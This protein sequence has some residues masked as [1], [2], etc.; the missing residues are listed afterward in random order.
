MSLWHKRGDAGNK[1]ISD[2]STVLYW[3]TLEFNVQCESVLQS[4]Q[5]PPAAKNTSSNSLLNKGFFFI[6]CGRRQ[7]GRQRST[8]LPEHSSFQLDGKSLYSES[9]HWNCFFRSL[10][11]FYSTE[12]NTLER[13]RVH[14]FRTFHFSFLSDPG[15]YH[16][17][18]VS[19][20][21]GNVNVIFWLAMM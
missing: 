3:S 2:Q 12:A 4:L 17:Q 19:G 18:P 14:R 15:T 5:A 21:A 9:Q 7:A 13:A 20:N 1:L 16:Q 6:F 10:Q 11:M 8:F